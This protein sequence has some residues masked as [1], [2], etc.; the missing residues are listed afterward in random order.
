M[1]I[2]V[3]EDEKKVASS[4]KKGLEKDDY[5]VTLSYD[6]SEGLALA[7]SGEF[8]LVILDCMLPKMDGLTVLGE[9]RKTGSLI[10]VLMLMAK[11]ETA[12]IV[13]CLNAGA[14]AYMAK[15][16]DF[17]EFQARIRAIIRRSKQS[18]GADIHYADMKID[19]VNH[20]VWRGKTEIHLSI[21]EY[22]M[23]AYLVNN[24]EKTVVRQEIA[25]NCWD[26]PFDTFTNVIDVYINY[27]RR[28]V[29]KG[30][31][32]SKLIHTV[33]GKGYTITDKET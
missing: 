25:D 13:A 30:Q 3:V 8:D 11:A 10:P 24:A 5:K 26:E 6:G 33:R 29:D 12:D 19:P 17:A 32:G 14:D 21:K 15:P 2:L 27:L 31:F 18:K 9:L 28:K 16:F 7:I 4:I 1:N 20:K 22:R 23:L